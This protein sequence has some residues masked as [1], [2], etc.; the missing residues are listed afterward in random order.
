MFEKQNFLRQ[1]V[2]KMLQ[3]TSIQM[4]THNQSASVAFQLVSGQLS[5]I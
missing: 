1:C 5:R 4:A 3:F 2:K